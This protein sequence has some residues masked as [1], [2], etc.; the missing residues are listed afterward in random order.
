MDDNG[1]KRRYTTAGVTNRKQSII[2]TLAGNTG[3][4]PSLQPSS[5]DEESAS[6]PDSGSFQV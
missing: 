1:K 6:K 4:R 5:I 2:P 3:R